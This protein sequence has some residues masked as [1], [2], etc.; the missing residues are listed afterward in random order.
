MNEAE[1]EPVIN[2]IGLPVLLRVRTE[3]KC[4]KNVHASKN[5][6]KPVRPITDFNSVKRLKTKIMKSILLKRT[7]NSIEL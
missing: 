7:A 3:R 1:L 6:G 5:T 2:L 4:D